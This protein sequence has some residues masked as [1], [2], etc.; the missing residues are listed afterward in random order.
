MEKIISVDKKRIY[1]I[2]KEDILIRLKLIECKRQLTDAEKIHF[3][4]SR[5]DSVIDVNQDGYSICSK[6]DILYTYGIGPC[7][8]LVL[9][10]ENIRMLFH[11]DGSI[12]L[13][14]VLNITDKVNLSQNTMVIVIPGASC[15]IENSFNYE[16]IK[17]KYKN[18]GYKVM[19]QRIS[20]D[21]GFIILDSEKVTIGTSIDRRLDIIIPIPIRKTKVKSNEL[22][23]DTIQETID[24]KDVINNYINEKKR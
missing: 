4:F 24:L 17:E 11:L 5:K 16:Q 6:D 10:D 8:G 3:G 13:E 7:C 18:K 19:E 2:I 23:D 9:C 20:T 15:S 14:D 22:I 21:L 1:N 12:S